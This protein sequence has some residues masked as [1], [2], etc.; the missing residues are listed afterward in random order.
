MLSTPRFPGLCSLSFA[1]L[2]TTTLATTL[3]AEDLPGAVDFADELRGDINAAVAAKE[4]DYVPRTKHLAADGSASYTNRLVLE[5]SPYLLQHAHNPVNWYPWGDAAF[6]AARAENKPVLL[7][8]GYSTCHWCHVMEDES[9]DNVEIASYLNRHYIAIKVDREARPD[10]D[11]IYM[12]AVQALTGRGGWPMTVWLTP[13]REPFYGGSYFPPYDGNRGVREGFYTLLQSLAGIYEN[14]SDG[15]GQASARLMASVRARMVPAAGEELPGEAVFAS[16]YARLKASYDPTNGGIAGAPKFPSQLPIRFLLRAYRH[17]EDDHVKVMVEHSLRSMAA[18][19]MYDQVGGG[20]HRYATD[21]AWQVPHFE[22]MLYDNALL[23][24]TYLEAFQ[25]TGRD[26][27]AQICRGI[28]LYADR[29]MRS[30]EGAFFSATDAD[31]R[32]SDGEL[33]EGWYFTWAKKEIAAV[34]GDR[35]AAIANAYFDIGDA[36]DIDGRNILRVASSPAT[37]AATFDKTEEEVAQLIENARERL[38]L[39]RQD[40]PPPFRDGKILTAWNGLMISAFAR[41]ALDLDDDEYLATASRAARF[42]IENL[43]QDGRLRRSYTNGKASG[44]AYADDYAYFIQAL[45]DLYEA[46][47]DIEWFA[48]AVRLERTMSAEFEDRAVGGFFFSSTAGEALLTREKPAYDGSTP[49]ANSIAVLNL[50]RLYEFTSDDD[51]RQRA[52]KTLTFFGD[53]I[54]RS[55]AALSEMLQALDFY[56][57]NAMEIVIVTVKG[58]TDAAPFLQ[59]LGRTFLPNHV[60]MV[61]SEGDELAGQLPFIPLLEGKR[62]IRGLAT[63]YVCEQGICDLPTSDPATFARQ[64]GAST[65]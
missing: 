41:A 55:P 62:A 19:G 22:K 34:L 32:S 18:G 5:S 40:R 26:E 60:L 54:T 24:M 33:V 45:I 49:S 13:D 11:G 6:A 4:S 30:A 2:L 64:I 38:Y 8:V 53:V 51:Y 28:L 37:V 29:D 63:A 61:V 20:F 43:Q 42:I 47:G 1:L 23:A 56:H 36:G 17:V 16:A 57:D 35:D 48:H 21:A 10:I 3:Q 58:R 39:A 59:L 65:P 46:S 12:A 7:S 44:D 52:E 15:V 25:L 50:L 9:F 31:S 14:N 27:F